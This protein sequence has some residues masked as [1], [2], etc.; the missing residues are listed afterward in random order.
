M[1]Y[2]AYDT[3]RITQPDG[4][5]GTR[6][7]CVSRTQRL[8]RKED[9]KNGGGWGSRAASDGDQHDCMPLQHMTLHYNALHY[10][11]SQATVTNTVTS[12]RSYITLHYITLHYITLRN[13]RRRPTRSQARGVIQSSKKKGGYSSP[14]GT[15][16]SDASLTCGCGKKRGVRSGAAQVRGARR[17]AEGC[18]SAGDDRSLAA[19]PSTLL[20]RRSRARSRAPCDVDRDPG[21]CANRRTRDTWAS[22]GPRAA[23]AR[24]HP[25]REKG[26]S[27]GFWHAWAVMMMNGTF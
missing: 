17:G 3:L 10:I 26:S 22:C 8:A 20:S 19:A 7:A 15:R 9:L 11:T 18:G 2:I 21:E 27:S 1:H 16:A 5:D 12:A 23:R 4:S 25:R 24:P 13:R 14:L 6:V